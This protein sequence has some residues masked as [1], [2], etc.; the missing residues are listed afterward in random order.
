MKT[1]LILSAVPD[2]RLEMVLNETNSLGYRSIF[3]KEKDLSDGNQDPGSQPFSLEGVPADRCY[4][5]DWDDTE[6]LLSIAEKEAVDGVIGL[7]DK[8][9]IPVARLS[10]ALSLP[11]NSPE[12]IELL[13]SK[14]RFRSLQ[15]KAGVFCPRHTNVNTEEDLR[16]ACESMQLP[17][18]VKPV[19][20]SS[21]FGQTI[22]ES[23]S[24][25]EEAFESASAY[26]RSGEVT[27]EEYILMPDLYIIEMDVFVMNGEI[28]WDGIRRNWRTQKAPLRPVYDVYPPHLSD[29]EYEKLTDT[30]KRVL[31]AAGVTHGEYNVEGFFTKSGEFFIV[32]I[33]PRQAG[34]YNPQDIELYSGVSF[35]R[36]LVTT[37]VS[38]LDYYESL[39][40]FQRT[41]R[42]II[43]YS[44]FSME[45]GILDHIHI[46]PELRKKIRNFRYLHGQK[47]GDEVLSIF[48]AKR[49]IAHITF[50][51]D[52]AE[53]LEQTRQKITQLLYPILR[54]ARN[55]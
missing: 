18:I 13:L 16:R 49:P 12:S 45:K 14:D 20:C 50:E 5:A 34:H 10:K 40:N 6:S 55:S 11:G 26:S 52:S 15:E 28:L 54:D 32:E 8:A 53:E 23:V 27:V 39:N 43:G 29:E 21:S 35:T 2:E 51:F 24:D 47:E 41:A 31:M 37:S 48:E 25:T 22:L 36:L 4:Q 3:C 9:M 7:V 19:H 33:N 38:E 30:T 42:N 1:V 17:V 44:L 46:D